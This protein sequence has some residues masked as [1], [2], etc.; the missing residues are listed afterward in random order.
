[1][2]EKDLTDG[3]YNLFGFRR[4]D[5]ARSLRGIYKLIRKFNNEARLSSDQTF[6]RVRREKIGKL[7][8]IAEELRTLK[9]LL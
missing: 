2:N 6:I 4:E 9:E 1:M 3:S 7:E 5:I 8:I